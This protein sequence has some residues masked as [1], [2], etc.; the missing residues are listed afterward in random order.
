MA[1]ADKTD[2][3]VPDT[4][5]H[6]TVACKHPNGIILQ[7]C[8]PFTY[9]D[10]RTGREITEYQ[11]TGEQYKLNGF[12]VPRGPDFDAEKIQPLAGGF[13]LTHGIPADFFRQWME[14]NKDTD[15]VKNGLVFCMATEADARAKA[16]ERAK[17]VVSGLEPLAQKGDPRAPKRVEKAEK[18][19]A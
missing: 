7:L 16:K 8:A 9:T 1:G 19:A 11:K 4:A 10:P 15:L 13:G 3:K 17:D 2:T 14:Q 6:V 18:E 12:A 5:K